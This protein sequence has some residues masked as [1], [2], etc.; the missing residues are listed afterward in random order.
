MRSRAL[1]QL[2]S[3]FRRAMGEVPLGRFV[4]NHPP[5]T[6]RLV[7][8]LLRWNRLFVFPAPDRIDVL[9]N[10]PFNAER[11]RR[12][13]RLVGRFLDRHNGYADLTSVLAAVQETDLGG[14]WL[15]PI[16]LGEVLRRHGPFEILPGGMIARR[17]LGLGGWLMR[18]ARLALRDANVPISVEEILAERPELAEFAPCLRELLAEDPLVQSPDGSRFQIA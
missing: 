14:S 15:Q 4:A 18:R 7:E 5:Q 2:L 10:Y 16:L 13:N 11:L 17:K 9:T 6:R 8:R 1:E 3:D 12:L